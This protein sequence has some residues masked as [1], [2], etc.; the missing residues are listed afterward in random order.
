MNYV[1]LSRITAAIFRTGQSILNNRLRELG[2]SSGQMDFLYVITLYEGLSQLEL[3]E[4]TFVGKSATTKVVK[5]LMKH[6]YVYRETDSSD[7]RVYRLYLTERG[8]S[9]S[10]KI[11][12]T[13]QEFV[14]LHKKNLT[15]EEALQTKNSLENVLA[16]LL[17]EKARINEKHA[18]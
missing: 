7:K 2:I 9:V 8:R 1:N 12:E 14:L 3:S 10:Q 15:E 16:G 17:E 4:L 11:Q 5:I 13:F 18:K 6:G